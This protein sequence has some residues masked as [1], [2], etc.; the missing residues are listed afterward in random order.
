MENLAQA[1]PASGNGT[2]AIVIPPPVS[3]EGIALFERIHA[4]PFYDQRVAVA[5]LSPEEREQYLVADADYER[6][7]EEHDRRQAE[8]Q[9]RDRFYCSFGIR[10]ADCRLDN[11]VVSLPEQKKVVDA[12]RDYVATFDERAKR[13]QGVVLFGPAG[14]GKDHLAVAVCKAVYDRWTDWY[15]RK[16]IRFVTGLDLYRM[17]RDTMGSKS[18]SE[19]D[20][21]EPYVRASLLL[22]SD[23]LPPRGPLTDWQAGV[24]LDI[25]DA[26][27]RGLLPT[28][29]TVNIANGNEGDERMGA[30]T[31]DR[32]KDGAVCFYCDWPSYR[33]AQKVEA[34]Q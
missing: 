31:L 4:L 12:L 5:A 15:G 24:L 13:G 21:I 30:Q 9:E 34:T 11:F 7:K 1:T 3:S 8:E 2:P 20:V 25:I 16:F 22:L 27:Y 17:I 19:W 28:I 10:Y 6:R 23:P 18:T 14:T 26:R 33:K 29:V 32:L